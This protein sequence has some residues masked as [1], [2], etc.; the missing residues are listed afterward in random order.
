MPV[1]KHTQ[2]GTLI[3]WALGGSILFF[4][5]LRIQIGAPISAADTVIGLVLLATVASLILMH[6]L[7]VT[8]DGLNLTAHLGP[9]LIRRS[10][11]LAAIRSARYV[12]NAWYYG[13][14]L[15]VTTRGPLWRVSGF[16]AVEI[17]LVKGRWLIGTDDPEELLAAIRRAPHELRLHEA[18]PLV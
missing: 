12:N 14:G 1:Y 15:R 10:V 18:E 16:D 6:S 2:P 11:P 9:G 8:I 13:W 17:E 3:R 5:A 7:T 4:L